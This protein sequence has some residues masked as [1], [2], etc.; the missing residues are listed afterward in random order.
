[1]DSLEQ[2][3]L[4]GAHRVGVERDRR[5]HPDHGEEL[6]QVVWHH[7]PQ[8]PRSLVEPAATLDTHSLSCRDLH[9]VDMVTV[10]ERLEDAVR[11]S[12][13]QNVLDRFLAEEMIDPIDLVFGQH[14]EDLRVKCLRGREVVP[15]RFFDDHPPPCFLRLLGQP[16][17]AELLDHRTKEPIG[18]GQ[19]EQHIGGIVLLLPLGQQPLEISEGLRLSKIS[20]HVAHAPGEP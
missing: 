17:V 10:P 12:Q 20:A 6:E 16:G 9:M 14:L 5:L 15:E 11:K 8:R 7:V 18:D 19:I 13:H 2:L 1:M 4:F 3:G